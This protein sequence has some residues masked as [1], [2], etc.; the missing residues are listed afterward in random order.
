MLSI[1]EF[2]IVTGNYFIS[3]SFF[4]YCNIVYADIYHFGYVLDALTPP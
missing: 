2:V 4:V 1:V 3:Q